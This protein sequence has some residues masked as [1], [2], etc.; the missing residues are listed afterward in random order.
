MREKTPLTDS[1]LAK[2]PATAT[3]TLAETQ[4]KAEEQERII[5]SGNREAFRR[6]MIR[7]CWPED[8]VGRLTGSKASYVIGKESYLN[9]SGP[10][11]EVKKIREAV[12]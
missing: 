8:A 6:T 10:E 7:G 11:L 2:G 1:L 3:Y 4:R 5:N 9:F 12:N